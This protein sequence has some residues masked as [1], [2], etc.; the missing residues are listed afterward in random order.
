MK[1]EG[2]M[3]PPKKLSKPPVADLKKWTY[4]NYMTKNFKIIIRKILREQ[5]FSGGPVF[6]TL[7]CHCYGP[8]FNPW[9]E[10]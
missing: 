6:R 10:N 3:T 4:R 1:N 9:L 2:N 5:E 8:G 7:H